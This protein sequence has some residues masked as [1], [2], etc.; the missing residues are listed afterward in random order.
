M[1]IRMTH[2][3]PIHHILQYVG[4]PLRFFIRNCSAA[5]RLIPQ[6]KQALRPQAKP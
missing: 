4:S 5:G 6:R 3:Y 2:V 1:C